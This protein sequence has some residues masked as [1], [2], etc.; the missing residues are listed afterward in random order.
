M[1]D[2]AKVSVTEH[3]GIIVGT[4][5]LPARTLVVPM[6]KISGDSIQAQ[7][8]RESLLRDVMVVAEHKL[9]LSEFRARMT[10]HAAGLGKIIYG[11]EA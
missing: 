3:D 10:I 5:E 2:V 6:Q 8:V 7:L 4:I 9:G 1:S 11:E